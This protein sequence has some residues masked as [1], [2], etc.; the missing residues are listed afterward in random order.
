VRGEG[1]CTE[2]RRQYHCAAYNL[3]IAVLSS[4]QTDAKF[5]TA[6]LFKEDE[7]KVCTASDYGG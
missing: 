2:L 4:T 5:F 7:A 3:L 1:T 6:F